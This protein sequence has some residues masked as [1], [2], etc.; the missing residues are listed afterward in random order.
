MHRPLS[1]Q[2]IAQ[3]RA[4]LKR[5]GVVAYPTESCYGL[6]ALPDN[7]RGLRT[8]LRLKKRPQHKGMIVIGA[9]WSQLQ[10]HLC[11]L[12]C[13]DIAALQ[14]MWPAPKTVLLPAKPTV[15]P[16]L[17]GRGRN[18]LAVRIPAHDTARGLCQQVQ[19]ALVSTSCNRA[20]Q[21][22]C[23][24]EREVR[25]QFGRQVYVVG[26]RVGRRRQ[27]SEIMDWASQKRIR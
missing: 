10:P 17:R 18:K 27:P 20:K 3:L 15:L 5:G 2:Q 6:G 24:N 8:L 7:V 1:F 14:A 12:P 11:R 26:G 16:N 19:A 13:D 22:P 23:R 25:R 9:N 21:R 4:H